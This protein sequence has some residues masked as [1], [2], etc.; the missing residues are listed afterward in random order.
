VLDQRGRTVS[1]LI[2]YVQQKASFDRVH[3]EDIRRQGSAL[4]SEYDGVLATGGFLKSGSRERVL[5][6]YAE[7]L[8][9]TDRPF[10]GICLG[11][12]IL[13][14]CYGAR[15]RKI[16]PDI[17]VRQIAFEREFPL[18]PGVRTM[19][20]YENHRYELV[21]PLPVPLQNYASGGSPVQAVT[22]TGRPQ[23]AV[24]FH[25][26]VGDTSTVVLDRFLELCRSD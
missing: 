17:G 23:F 25:P 10:L 11:M 24:Q 20:V 1:E 21:P 14:H 4:A 12:K 3:P 26:E 6:W 9:E 15:L 7:L 2:R 16:E 13:G 5:Q 19:A 8:V 22:V 18:A